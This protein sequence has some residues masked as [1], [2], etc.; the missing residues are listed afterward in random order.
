MRQ[1]YM[2]LAERAGTFR[3]WEAPTGYRWLTKNEEADRAVVLVHGV[4]GSKVDMTVL[5][6]EFVAR[7]FAVYTPD[8]PGHGAAAPVE[9]KSFDDLGDWLR[10]F[11]DATG[12]IPAA[13]VGNSFG[14]AICYNY[15]A[16]GHMPAGTRLVLAC[17][18]PRVAAVTRA[19]VR[20]SGLLPPDFVTRAYNRPFAIRARVAYLSRADDEAARRWLYESE[21]TKELYLEARV[22]HRLTRLLHT[23]NPYAAALLP[24]DVQ[25]RTTV[26][27][28][29]DDNVVTGGSIAALREAMPGVRTVEVPGA[30]HILHFEAPDRI[31]AAAVPA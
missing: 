1:P 22:M 27:I 8:L 17:P 24:V 12:R 31:A 11:V 13:V 4:T 3:E 21:Y 2:S 28:G 30:G 6:D 18:T 7:G 20:V 15:A 29:T 9:M 10:G 14:S 23:H 19:L 26:V 5:G 16:R 25:H